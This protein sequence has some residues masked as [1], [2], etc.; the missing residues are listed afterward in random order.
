MSGYE[1][2]FDVFTQ[3]VNK[4]FFAADQVAMV[5]LGE[6]GDDK[7]FIKET[8]KESR[9]IL[10]SRVGKDDKLESDLIEAIQ[11]IEIK[12]LEIIGK[13]N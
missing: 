10:Y 12:C 5:K 9:E 3:T 13:N 7:E 1:Q 4:I 8:M 11:L 6:Y 2:H